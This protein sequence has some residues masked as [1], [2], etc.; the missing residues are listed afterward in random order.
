MSNPKKRA[1]SVLNR[2]DPSSEE[3]P[4]RPHLGRTSRRKHVVSKRNIKSTPGASNS[5][6]PCNQ[7][8]A[9]KTDLSTRSKR[10]KRS[11]PVDYDTDSTT[12]SRDG[13]V[14]TRAQ[15]SDGDEMSI[16]YN[17]HSRDASPSGFAINVPQR[18]T[19][20]EMFGIGDGLGD[21]DHLVRGFD[22]L[23]ISSD[24][25]G[26]KTSGNKK[27][28][29]T[30]E[31]KTSVQKSGTKTAVQALGDKKAVPTPETTNIV[32]P[33]K[34]SSTK[35][36]KPRAE[37]NSSNS[38][39]KKLPGPK[40]EKKESTDPNGNRRKLSEKAAGKQAIR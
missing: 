24:E 6:D 30:S 27:A 16:T 11:R 14:K 19:E 20:L 26:E 23:E 36:Y 12:R 2:D 5:L 21:L 34:K 32:K 15:H 1:G 7:G 25:A 17:D 39:A 4:L 9:S 3:E 10:S 28:V 22:D 38:R 18:N 33:A 35:T 31:D 40:E 13:S 29:K 8:G 37:E